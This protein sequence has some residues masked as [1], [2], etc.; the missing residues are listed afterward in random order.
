MS[1]SLSGTII[2]FFLAGERY[3]PATDQS[4][5]AGAGQTHLHR[6]TG[7]LP[8]SRPRTV[9]ELQIVHVAV[10]A[11]SIL[12]PRANHATSFCRIF[13]S[14]ISVITVIFTR[15]FSTLKSRFYRTSFPNLTQ[16]TKSVSCNVL[17]FDYNVIN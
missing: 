3:A 13:C 16:G 2:S 6:R 7:H 10:R 14:N 1:A 5:F 4:P 17:T 12:M 15:D 9:P 8:H 11:Q